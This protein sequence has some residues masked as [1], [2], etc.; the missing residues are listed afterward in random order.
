MNPCGTLIIDLDG[1]TIRGIQSPDLAGARVGVQLNGMPERVVV[2]RPVIEGEIERYVGN[3]R[4]CEVAGAGQGL[5]R[6]S[7]VLHDALVD[8]GEQFA[9]LTNHLPVAIHAKIGRSSAEVLESTQALRPH[10]EETKRLA[11]RVLDALAGLD[12]VESEMLAI[13]GWDS[14]AA[15]GGHHQQ[16]QIIEHQEH[17]HV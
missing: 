14:E 10:R 11:Q 8:A 15:H 16:P 4:A 3:F 1:S 13:I 6:A 9:L 2:V 17:A 12:D 5:D 7:D